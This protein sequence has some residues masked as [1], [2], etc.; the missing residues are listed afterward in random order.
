[1]NAQYVL[2]QVRISLVNVEDLV[3]KQTREHWA[4]AKI[5]VAD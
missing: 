3:V 4:C 1:M 5:V 2:L